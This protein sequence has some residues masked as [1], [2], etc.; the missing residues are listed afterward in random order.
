[1]PVTH[2][3]D[4]VIPVYNEKE[5]F[6]TAYAAIKECVKS[7][8]RILMVYDLPEDT[9]LEAAQGIART[10]PRIV[11]V[12]NRERGVLAAIKTGFA[13]AEADAVLVMMVDDPREVVK[14]ID[15]MV[16]LFF[17]E[18]ATIVVASRYMRGGRHTGGPLIKGLLSRIAG[19]SLH[20]FIGLPTHDA[21]YAT[22]LYRKSFL[23]ATF[24]ESTAGFV[25]T[26]E[27]TLK[28]YF[29]GQRIIEIPVH[30]HERLVGESRFNLEKW[31]PL[32]LRWYIWALRK[33]YIPF[34]G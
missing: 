3:V 1:M 29:A 21:T 10:D 20:Y 28:A 15:D 4:I 11:L 25:L 30:W 22:R 23:D 5:N 31:L 18:S 9:T 26:I 8:W 7:D 19:V 34:L 24:I 6:Q 13:Q 17:A 14:K 16:H 2:R 27:L 33:R 32:Y 12:R